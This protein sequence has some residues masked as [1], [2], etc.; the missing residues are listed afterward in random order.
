MNVGCYVVNMLRFLSGAEPR[1]VEARATVAAPGVDKTM[2]A[3]FAFD[4]G[5]TGKMICSHKWPALP[6]ITARV[7][8]ARG[9]L[10]VWNPIVPHAGRRLLGRGLH[11]LMVRTRTRRRSEHVSGE[12]TYRYQLSAFADAIRLSGTLPTGPLDAVENMSVIDSIYL[13]AGL[14]PRGADA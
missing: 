1:V 8:G 2:I 5:R 7:V 9:E 10:R 4:D 11:W 14:A 12:S 3:D 6:I 13:R